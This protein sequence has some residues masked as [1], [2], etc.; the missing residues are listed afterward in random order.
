MFSFNPAR[1]RA[2]VAFVPDR[3]EFAHGVAP[4]AGLLAACG[5]AFKPY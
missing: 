1:S 2:A 3:D 5:D 4:I